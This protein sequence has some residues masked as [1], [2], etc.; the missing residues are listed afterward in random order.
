MRQKTKVLAAAIAA[1]LLL[2]IIP[3]TT[4]E[5]PQPQAPSSTFGVNDKLAALQADKSSGYD[6]PDIL[7]E[8]KGVLD[9]I[10]PRL[11]E[12]TSPDTNFSLVEPVLPDM[13]APAIFD[14]AENNTALN[15]TSVIQWLIDQPLSYWVHT[16]MSGIDT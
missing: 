10:Q 12:R 11:T 2:N 7:R 6:P 8:T 5:E 3:L 14:L 9:A 16:R 4:S 1:L 15:G 13:S